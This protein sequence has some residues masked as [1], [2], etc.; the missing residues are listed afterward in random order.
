MLPLHHEHHQ[1]RPAPIKGRSG[2]RGIR[3][4]TPR[5]AH[6][7]AG[8]PGQPYPAT[9]RNAEIEWTAGDLN[10]GGTPLGSLLGANQVSCHWTSRPRSARAQQ[11]SARD[12]NPNHLPTTEACRPRTCGPFRRSRFRVTINP[13]VPEG[14]EPPFPLCKRGVVAAGPR[15]EEQLEVARVGVEP[16]GHESLSLAALPVCVP[17]RR[18]MM[19]PV[20]A[21]MGVEPH[22][23]SS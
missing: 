10:P 11:R 6:S 23:P 3:T 20:I 17:C 1:S 16:T 8:R 18:W 13:V 7:L 21:G 22:P 19:P 15:D 2:R 12:S 14:I 4:L 5:R 9:F